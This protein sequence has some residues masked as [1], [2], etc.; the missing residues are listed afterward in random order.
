MTASDPSSSESSKSLD[1]E[2][3]VEIN[4]IRAEDRSPDDD[5]SNSSSDSNEHD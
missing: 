1:V 3:N 5:S 2:D 4:V